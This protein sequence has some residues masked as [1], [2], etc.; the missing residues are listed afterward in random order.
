MFVRKIAFGVLFV[1]SSLSAINS[2]AIEFK[3]L[4]CDQIQPQPSASYDV[5]VPC[6]AVIQR[7]G[8]GAWYNAPSQ[9]CGSFCRAIASVNIP[10][11][12]GFNCTSGEERPQSAIGVVNFAPTGCWHDCREPEG[13]PGATSVGPRCYAPG[14]KRDNDRTDIT[15]GCF[16][17]TGDV[18]SNVV[19]IGIHAS[20]TAQSRG[21]GHHAIGWTSIH[22][23]VMNDLPGRVSYIRGAIPLSAEAAVR[24]I[25]NIQGSCGT[26]VLM[27][28]RTNGSGG[29]TDTSAEVQIALPDCQKICS[30]AVDNDQDGSVDNDDFS[31]RASNGESEHLPQA[32][33]E[34]GEDDDNDGLFDEE[35]P[36]CA[37]TQDDT[38]DDPI[39]VCET[40]VDHAQDV[41]ALEG[42][43]RAQRVVVYELVDP[44]IKTVVDSAIKAKAQELRALADTVKRDLVRNLNKK[45]P[46][47]TQQCPLCKVKDLT[48]IK[49]DFVRQ[50]KRMQRLT[51][52]VVVFAQGLT[53]GINARLRLQT[54]EALF[55]QFKERVSGLP[56]QTAA[57]RQ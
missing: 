10:S 39:L 8:G 57:C 42:T 7:V 35:D 13:R 40:V 4:T 45:Y 23:A 16:C 55:L 3:S 52:Q 46:K 44:I 18:Y 12:D 5:N 34:N 32:A 6:T 48:G 17:A 36:G 50:S 31:C 38:E 30:D 43:I 28:G 24:F 2:Y 54:A 26:R 53:P 33:C 1:L 56:G 41:I 9:E 51:R 15:L 14:Q 27:S 11:P 29:T 22:A 20:G 49:N 47:T 37:S 19:D 25:V 21:V